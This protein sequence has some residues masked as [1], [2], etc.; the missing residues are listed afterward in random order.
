M[1][2]YFEIANKSDLLQL[3]TP[4]TVT[5]SVLIRVVFK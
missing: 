3:E 2:N 4:R 5:E 1:L